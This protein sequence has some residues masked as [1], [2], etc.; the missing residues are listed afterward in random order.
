MGNVCMQKEPILGQFSKI[1]DRNA[2]GIEHPLKTDTH[3]HTYAQLQTETILR[4][5]QCT[6]YCKYMYINIYFISINRCWSGAT[7]TKRDYAPFTEYDGKLF[8]LA[9]HK[10][11]TALTV[12][13]LAVVLATW[14]RFGQIFPLPHRNPIR[15]VNYCQYGTFSIQ[16]VLFVVLIW[17]VHVW[18]CVDSVVVF[19]NNNLLIFCLSHRS[20]VVVVFLLLHSGE[21]SQTVWMWNLRCGHMQMNISLVARA[22]CTDEE[23]CVIG[24]I[25]MYWN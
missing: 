3:T 2:N 14:K 17:S 6:F 16:F 23:K 21:C 12:P 19:N 8:R 18:S 4:N 25:E 9:E 5:G 20:I 11:T 10:W 24:S 22:W 7:R 1:Y 13:S 15:T